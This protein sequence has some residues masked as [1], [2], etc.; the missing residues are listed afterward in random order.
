MRPQDR[1][2]FSQAARQYGLWILVRR[3]NP[4]SLRYVGLAG[5]VP[6]PI[7][8]KA[9]TADLD[10]NGGQLAGLVADP[11]L[12]RS[13]FRPTKI[14]TALRCWQQLVDEQHVGK[15][16]ALYT[17]VTDKASPK[18]GALQ[19][20]GSFIHGDYDLY[21]VIDPSQA[22]RNLAA[23]ET[24][25][26]QPHMR[27]PNFYKVQHYVNGLIGSN[28]VQHGGAIQYSDHSDEDIDAFGPEGEDCTVLR[29]AIPAWYAQKF[30]GRK[31]IVL[32]GK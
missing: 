29:V 10:V 24:L 23:V 19:L 9:K 3:T 4:A 25:S 32:A 31:P 26:G 15:P 7:E 13:A 2:A 21:D 1:L 5:Y 30:E 17:V 22:Y 12:C 27:G 20:K 6:K 16:G 18:Y 14:E 28:M 11:N 8:C